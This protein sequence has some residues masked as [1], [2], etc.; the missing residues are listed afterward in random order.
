ML[1]DNV[2][3]IETILTNNKDF[4]LIDENNYIEQIREIINNYDKYIEQTGVN[5]ISVDQFVPTTQM[6]VWQKNIVVQGNLDPVILLG[7]KEN[8]K[9][10]VDRIIGSL[11]SINFIFNLGHGILP[12]TPVNNVEYLINYVKSFR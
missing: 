6:K 11:D 8:I 3:G 7:S 5:G 12:T 2:E 9:V 10:A 1:C 4:I